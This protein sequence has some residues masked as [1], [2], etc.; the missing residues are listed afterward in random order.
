MCAMC[1]ASWNVLVLSLYFLYMW[2]EDAGP[3]N[4]CVFSP[5][6]GITSPLMTTIRGTLI[7]ARTT[8]GEQGGAGLCV[9][10]RWSWVVCQC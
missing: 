3:T 9:S 2:A 4:I 8:T 6:V 1:W 10:A 5:W 7:P